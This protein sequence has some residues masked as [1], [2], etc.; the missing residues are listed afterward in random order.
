MVRFYP[1]S[2]ETK[3]PKEADGVDKF[4]DNLMLY[5]LEHVDSKDKLVRTRICQLM[6]ACVNGIDELSDSLWNL[7][8]SKMI[9]R[10]FDKEPTVRIQ[11][12]H[13]T[14]RLQVNSALTL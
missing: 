6:V 1:F 12:V 7:F 11:A 9:E 4:I 3:G 5:L 8:R 10:L 2:L 13:T 14:A